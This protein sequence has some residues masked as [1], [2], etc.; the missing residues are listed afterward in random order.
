MCREIKPATQNAHAFV[1][2]RPVGTRVREG[3][4]ISS[5]ETVKVNLSLPSPFAG[6]VVDVNPSLAMSPELVNRDPYGEGWLVSLEL[7]GGAAETAG[8]MEP[9]A[10][11]AHMRA[12]AEAEVASK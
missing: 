6:V 8:L 3:D 1:E 10:Y 11:L 9:A 5:V 4:D 7:A 12:L 2:A